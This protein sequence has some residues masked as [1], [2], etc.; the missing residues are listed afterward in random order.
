MDWVGIKLRNTS[1]FTF[2]KGEKDLDLLF[3]YETLIVKVD[4]SE[5]LH[6]LFF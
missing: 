5:K 4:V 1:K 3:R 6:R 2:N